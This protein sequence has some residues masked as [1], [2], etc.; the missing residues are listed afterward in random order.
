[1]A[2]EDRLIS[3]LD[4]PDRLLKV[5]I[6]LDRVIIGIRRMIILF[7]RAHMVVMMALVALENL[8][9]MPHQV[10]SRCPRCR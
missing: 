8:M 4:R 3:A 2:E 9:V 6:C 1:M 7:G 5:D 10:S